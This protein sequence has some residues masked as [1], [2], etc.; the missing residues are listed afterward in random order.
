MNTVEET[1]LK[2]TPERAKSWIAKE[3]VTSH[4]TLKKVRQ[5]MSDHLEL[6]RS[7]F[8]MLVDQ[9]LILVVIAAI[10]AA[11]IAA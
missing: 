11:L 4:E 6:S 5:Q 10:V 3:L 8:I 7:E 2:E 1:R 9:C